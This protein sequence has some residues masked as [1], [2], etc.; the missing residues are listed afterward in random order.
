MDNKGVS[1]DGLGTK[2]PYHLDKGSK[3]LSIKHMN[4]TLE[5]NLRHAEEHLQ[6]A[7]ESCEKLDKA[8]VKHVLPISKQML[9]LFNYFQETKSQN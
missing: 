5:Y 6:K 3:E 8:G 9:D 7:K 2:G 1:L 4:D